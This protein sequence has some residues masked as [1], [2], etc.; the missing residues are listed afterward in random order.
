[1]ALAYANTLHADQT[2]KG[3]GIPYISHLL[4]VAALTLE[5]GGDEDQAIGALLHD[6]VEDQ[7]GLARA[8]DIEQRFGRRVRD[9]VLACSDAVTDP[10]PDWTTRKTA[11][12][13]DIAAK[14]P[15]AILVTLAD[16][17]HNAQCITDD[18]GRVGA[19][20]WDR[21]SEPRDR[22]IWY[23]GALGDA[24]AARHPGALSDRL[25]RLV[26][27]FASMAA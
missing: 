26:T 14:H 18:F 24:L 23:Y 12:I 7:G 8:D 4:S 20:V 16:K 21:F 9:I 6:A 11:Y 10:K 27:G 22:V 2:R 13:A 3:S 19:A 5:N 25:L 17:V 1:V 15:D